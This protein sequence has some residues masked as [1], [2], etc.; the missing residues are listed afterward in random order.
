VTFGIGNPYQSIG[1]AIAHPSRQLYTDSEVNLA[2]ATGKLRWYYQAVPDDFVDHDLQSSPISAS[3]GAVP[4][5]ITSGKV[6][7]V[8]ALNAQSGA[9]VW[10]TPVGEHNGHDDDSVL[11]L[12]HQLTLKLP[13]TVEPGSLGGVLS[14]M[15]VA[16]GS[17][18]VATIDLAITYTSPSSVTGNKA[19]SA[20]TGE[21]EAL[22][23]ATGRVEWDTKVP[24][25]PLG[26]AT[27]SNDLLFTTL[28]NGVLIALDRGT[29]AVVYRRQLPTSANAPIA[30]FGNT[31]LVPA[32][33]PMTSSSGG[34][35]HPQLV[36]Y[37]VP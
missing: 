19:A 24:S 1:Q 35:G 11:A 3:I 20:A 10:K 28:Y 8:Y 25:M 14:N 12:S 32:G 23:L 34:G 16:D 21:V 33:G 2:A 37:T 22:S 26:A 15:A 7:Y 13:Y 30:V 5:I 36:A 29:G 4:V 27:V 6:G 9:L 31:A 17:V 18:Y